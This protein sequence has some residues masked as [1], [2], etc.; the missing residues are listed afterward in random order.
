MVL[1]VVDTFPGVAGLARL[2]IPITG[3][4]RTSESFAKAP[5]VKQAR[6]AGFLSPG[7]CECVAKGRGVRRKR[8]PTSAIL[9]ATDRSEGHRQPST[10]SGWQLDALN[11]APVDS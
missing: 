11:A 9:S 2:C 4:V 5:P 6:R 7:P 10:G 8:P 1:H 3:D